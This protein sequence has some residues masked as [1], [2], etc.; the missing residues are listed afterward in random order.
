M[1][2]SRT[3]ALATSGLVL[4]GLALAGCSTPS[5]SDTQKDAAPAVEQT[6]APAPAPDLTGTWKQTNSHS[7]DAYQAAQIKGDAIEVEWVTDGGDTTSL[8][9]AGSYEAPEKAGDYSWK[10]AN[11]T[12]KTSKSLLASPDKS[13][14]FTYSN[15]EIS[16]KVSL[17]G[18][19]TT[20]RLSKK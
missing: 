6:Q 12:K 8:Y 14:T 18:T 17:A 1:H 11:D 15:G 20:V 9:W 5:N 4:V 13:K 16:Y 19:T 3:R 10:S 2:T 7:T